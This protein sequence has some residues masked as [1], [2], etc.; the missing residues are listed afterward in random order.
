LALKNEH[1]RNPQERPAEPKH[2]GFVYTEKIPKSKEGNL[3][4]NTGTP[5]AG[6]PAALTPLFARENTRWELPVYDQRRRLRGRRSGRAAFQPPALRHPI[7]RGFF[8]AP[9]VPVFPGDR[10]LAK[11]ER[12][13]SKRFQRLSG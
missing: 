5:R 2:G 3:G 12:R 1:D 4:E 11:D 8:A 7:L 10:L 6:V 9:S 13:L